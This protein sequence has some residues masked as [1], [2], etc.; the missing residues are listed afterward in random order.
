[1]DNGIP[2]TLVA[3]QCVEAGVDL[4]FHTVYTDFQ[5]LSSVIQ[6]AGRTGRQNRFKG[7]VLV[8]E[9]IRKTEAGNEAP[10]HEVLLKAYTHNLPKTLPF[11]NELDSSANTALNLELAALKT[12][13]TATP[14]RVIFNAYITAN[15]RRKAHTL[16]DIKTPLVTN[17]AWQMPWEILGILS[18]LH[19]DADSATTSRSILTTPQYTTCLQHITT[20]NQAEAFK[21]INVTRISLSSERILNQLSYGLIP[22]IVD[23]PAINGDEH[24]IVFIPAEV[25][26]L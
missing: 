12:F 23:L 3:T 15:S 6:R 19:A 25:Q 14:E 5:N 2:V 11:K 17:R 18:Q 13:T 9:F 8:C 7:E 21:L 4:D 1:M 22:K 26:I 24:T 16:Q 10:S 20:G